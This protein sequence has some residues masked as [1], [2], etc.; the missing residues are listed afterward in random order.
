MAEDDKQRPARKLDRFGKI[1]LVVGILL[2]AMCALSIIP[3]ALVS[4]S[5]H[6]DGCQMQRVLGDAWVACF[7]IAVCSF[8]TVLWQK[9]I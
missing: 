8:A 7:W 2:S 1:C 3:L 4:M 5:C 6:I 9:V